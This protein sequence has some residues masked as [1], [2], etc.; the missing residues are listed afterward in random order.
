MADDT[1]ATKKAS[2]ANGKVGKARAKATA[3][4]QSKG[5]PSKPASAAKGP[6]SLHLMGEITWLMGHSK[7]HQDWPLRSLARWVLPALT[8]KH[9]RLFH[10]EG[11]PI[12]YVSWAWMSKEIEE[13]YIRNT[14]SLNPDQWKSGDRGWII[15][16]IAPFGDAKTVAKFLKN[17]LFVND[18][19]RSLRV[20][21]GKDMGYIRYLHG[22]KAVKDAQDRTKSPTVE[23]NLS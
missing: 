5:S 10:R 18:V 4:D 20:Y 15:D 1:G 23:I 7:L 12:A 11:R 3:T 16:F 13:A 2:K 19:G 8:H 6:A 14:N 9:Y 22:A 17:D 21:P